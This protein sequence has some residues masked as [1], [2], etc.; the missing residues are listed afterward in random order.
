MGTRILAAALCASL[1]LAAGSP[2]SAETAAQL[3]TLARASAQ[4]GTGVALARRQIDAGD[5][6]D[7]L[8]TLERVI[9]N[10]PLSNEARMLHAA[11]MCRLDDRR[12]ALVE[13][14]QMRGRQIPDS[15]WAEA[16]EACSGR[17]GR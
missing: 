15:L 8:A 17:Q 14:D 1:A 13:L 7:A 2:A 16:N 6:L 11:V 5:M 12:G 4:P 3:D 10:F 9:I